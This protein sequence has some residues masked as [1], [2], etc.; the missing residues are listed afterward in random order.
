MFLFRR[1]VCSVS[2][3]KASVEL[4]LLRQRIAERLSVDLLIA[5]RLNGDQRTVDRPTVEQLTAKVVI[6]APALVDLP[7]IVD[8]A[9]VGRLVVAQGVLDL[10]RDVRDPI[11]A[12]A[13]EMPTV[14]IAAMTDSMP[15]DRLSTAMAL[16][17][18]RRHGGKSIAGRRR[19]MAILNAAAHTI[20]API[21]ARAATAL[22]IIAT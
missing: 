11:S 18:V 4:V 19:R 20:S 3:D 8:R 9:T 2:V 22:A 21:M 5:D 15:T 1:L 16:T 14:Q 7:L 12:A 6:V 10:A 17:C 13:R